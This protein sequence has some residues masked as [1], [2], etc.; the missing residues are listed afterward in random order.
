MGAAVK[1][2]P[3]RDRAGRRQVM[4]HKGG[5]K[6]Q[7]QPSIASNSTPS[8]ATA[9]MVYLWSWGPIVGPVDGLRSVKLDGT[10]IVAADG[11]VNYPG[12][13]WQ[14]RSGELHQD[15]LDGV[16]ESSNEIDVQQE[17]LT[18]APYLHT[19]SNSM[20]DAVRVRLAWPQLQSQDS[21]GNINGVRIQ[22]AIDISTDNGAYVEVLASE[23]DRK[24]I[25]KYERSHRL[26]LPV[27]DRWTVRVRRLTPE[28]N[29]STVSDGMLVEAIAEVV[30][31]DQEYPLTAVSCVEY[32][33]QQ[34]GGDIA[35]ISVLMRGRIVQVPANYDPD[36]RTYMTSGPGTSNGIWDGTWK[37]AWTDCPP[38]IFRD[39]ALH[40]YYGLGDRIDSSMIDHWS[41]YRI[42]Q[43]CD[44]LVPDGKGG[45]QPRFTCNLYLQKQA[46][47][48]AVLQ[49]LAAIFHGLAFWDGSQI[50]VN[51]DMPQ[52]PV[53]TYTLSQILGDGAIKY[54]G[55]KARDRHSLAMVSWDNPDQGYE[56][57]KEPVFDDEAI[58][59]LGVRELSVEAVGCTSH[60]QAQRAGAW[61]LT[62]EQLQTREA[63]FRVG[64]DGHIPRPGQV[65]ALADPM[66]AGRANGG[67]VAAV[68]GRV[69]TL[70]RDIDVP[71]GSRLLVN[72][73][74]GKTEAR[75]VRS[76]DGRQVTVMA[77]FSEAPEPE[78]AWALDF[79]D[80]KLMQFYVRNITRP[81]WHQFQFEVIQHEPSKFDAIDYG[82][83]IDDR[84]ISV[85]P[86]GVQ[87]ASAQVLITSYVA[88]DQ[89]IAVNT[90]T[91]G[92]SVA[93]GAVAYDVEW[94]W[95][96]RDWIKLPRTGELSVDVR[97]IYAGQYMA[98][99]RAISAMDVASM[100][101]TSLLTELKGKEGLPPAVAYLTTRELVFGT[102]LAW[103]F[104]P[105]AED[106]QRTE[107]WQ[108]P[109][110]NRD[111]AIKLGDYA[112]P[113]A[114]HEIHGLAAGVTFFY[115]AR[116]IDR[117]DNV[118]PWYPEGSGVM[119]R[120]ST[121]LS[122]YEEYFKDKIGNG[123]LLPELREEIEKISGDGPGSVSD[124]IDQAKQDLYDRIDELTDAL[125]YDPA[126][127]YIAG[128]A[129]R[130]EQRLF[131]ARTDVPVG[132][133][134]P[135][136]AY[137]ADIGSVVQTVDAL[138]VQVE[139]NTVAIE[140][141][142]GVVT[143]QA[144]TLQ[145]LRA[146][147]R[148][149]DANGDLADVINGWSAQ[150]GIAEQR[151]VF[152]TEKRAT[153]ER[154]FSMDAQVGSN[155]AGLSTLET[156]VATDRLATASRLDQLKVGVDGNTAAIGAEAQVRADAI[157]A[158]TE[159]IDTTEVTVGQQAAKIQDVE[160]AQANTDQSVAA[161]R[162]TASAIFNA[163]RDDAGSG[164]LANVVEGWES[165]AKYASEIKLQATATRSLAE[166]SE[167]LEASIGE[168]GASVQQ[169]SQAVV[170]L[171]GKVSSQVTIK[172]QTFSGGRKVM[173]GLALGSDGETSEILAFAQRFAIVDEVSGSLIFP[174]VA[175]GGQVFMNS[176][177][178]KQADILNLIITGTLTSGD[179]VPGQ[180]GIMLN[181]VTG[182]FEL[183]GSVPG[184][185]RSVITNRSLRFWDATNAK[186]V[187]LGD[188]SE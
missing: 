41:L 127:T 156:I 25:T 47:A 23:V 30:D 108:S 165:A 9:R 154:F 133:A 22:Y 51:A 100:P 86:P 103:A 157:E 116:L 185:G 159:R 67:R 176:A 50:V 81:E 170:D 49:D 83:V 74:S 109:S 153:A 160:Q 57:D 180:S 42:A 58:A 5:A 110:P 14:F 46:E 182:K 104:P 123:A 91:I 37:E 82:T 97:G 26:E 59:E 98:R 1:R 66:L 117:S 92:W 35:K 136:P 112:H 53:Y 63:S 187:Q 99:V 69:L 135:D 2:K 89:G 107:I 113:Q 141:L 65:I 94:R 134:P 140:E 55:S 72:L 163:Q 119:G 179:Y 139:Q 168:T 32:D 164:A 188:L 76:V 138:A 29:S 115:W 120:A 93:P 36:T 132:A 149:R 186:R 75:Q 101:T 3:P 71:T 146:A 158:V 155:T 177:V 161:L 38:W 73:P 126:R 114:E 54:T 11:T 12:V 21:A 142:D 124:R 18:T 129:V 80:L 166:K 84:P 151:K 88:V 39:L 28:A 77:D 61:A 130:V 31:S 181:F 172:A 150:A 20:V 118:G 78:S 33:A 128:D 137:W 10:P 178:I 174:L 48:W 102:G 43:F 121:D 40:P 169:V 106:T 95:G 122:L 6:K 184:Q 8:I 44:Q 148:P 64:L 56:T 111:A 183:N 175:Q 70:D 45:Q 147:V 52:D 125:A 13:K 144:T 96:S 131:Q 60:G 7:K 24:N 145:S 85:L 16:S 171:D 105:G 143:A 19:V 90:M 79:D 4:G 68:S 62:T 17:L 152:A 167:R 87:E 15:R 162:T 34:F 27:G 173:A